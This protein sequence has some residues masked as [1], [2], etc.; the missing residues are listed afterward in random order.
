M[1]TLDAVLRNFGGVD[2]ES[3]IGPD[4]EE[5]SQSE[6][7][8]SE[9]A[10]I[11]GVYDTLA[12]AGAMMEEA[13]EFAESE[14]SSARAIWTTE[15]AARLSA[16]AAAGRERLEQR[17]ADSL[18]RAI[19]PFIDEY[20]QTRLISAMTDELRALIGAKPFLKVSITGPGQHLASIADAL[21]ATGE[22]LTFVSS[23][24]ARITAKIGETFLSADLAAWADRIAQKLPELDHV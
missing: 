12:R 15:C 5:S 22:A 10:Y 4:V 13:L 17:L 19:L 2:R 8:N 23:E 9:A 11:K 1:R 21:G 20:Q 18:L 6:T 24:E 3:S 16:E 14:I 7:Q